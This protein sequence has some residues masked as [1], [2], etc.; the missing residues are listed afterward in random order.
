M[1]DV[2]W[3]GGRVHLRPAPG[4]VRAAY[5]TGLVGVFVDDEVSVGALGAETTDTALGLGAGLGWGSYWSK[6]SPVRLN[7]EVDFVHIGWEPKWYKYNESTYDLV[8][9]GVGIHYFVM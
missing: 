9:L 6:T 1:I 5:L 3:I 7:V 4:P 8:M 2:D